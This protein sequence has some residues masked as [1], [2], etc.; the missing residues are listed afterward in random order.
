MQFTKDKQLTISGKAVPAK[1]RS[2]F[3]A[4]RLLIAVAPF[5]PGY[6]N[7]TILRLW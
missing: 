1:N 3:D 4:C 7:N 5:L 2:L 6:I